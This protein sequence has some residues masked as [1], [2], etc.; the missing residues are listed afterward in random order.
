MCFLCFGIPMFYV[1]MLWTFYVHFTYPDIW[2]CY[3]RMQPFVHFS[4]FFFYWQHGII[5][6]VYHQISMS[7]ILQRVFCCGLQFFFNT[8]LCSSSVNYPC[9]LLIIF[10]IGI[11][12]IS[13]GFPNRFLKC[14]F[15]FCILSFWLAAF[16][17]VLKVLFL[18]FPSFTVCHDIH[19][20]LS[21]TEVL[22]LL[23]WPWIHSSY[24]LKE[25]ILNKKNKIS[26]LKNSSNDNDSSQNDRR[27]IQQKEWNQ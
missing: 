7:S 20:C 19:D 8:A 13:G 4:I 10:V 11:S 22:I 6:E 9:W 15:H 23:I 2:L 12:V 5:E 18:S 14:S 17:F 1:Y 3:R 16:S 24:S 26:C 21:S 27:Y 25:G